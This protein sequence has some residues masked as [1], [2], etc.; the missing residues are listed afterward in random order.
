MIRVADKRSGEMKEYPGEHP[1]MLDRSYSG[2]YVQWACGCGAGRVLI[3]TT[4][5]AARKGAMDMYDGNRL[6]DGVGFTEPGGRSALRRATHRNPR[7][8]PCPTC[9]KA[10]M[11]TPADVRAGYQCDRC[12][13]R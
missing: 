5:R 11:L 9:K 1:L 6:I 4:E 7:N 13:D 3:H 8:H 12:A 10:N 2:K